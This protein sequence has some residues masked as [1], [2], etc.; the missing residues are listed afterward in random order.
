MHE[1]GQL[2]KREMAALVLFDPRIT[3]RASF[4]LRLSATV[5]AFR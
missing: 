3:V 4:S 2:L 5:A 1:V